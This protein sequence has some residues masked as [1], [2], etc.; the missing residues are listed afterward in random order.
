MTLATIASC[1]A[2][3]LPA[4]GVN[5][6]APVSAAASAVLASIDRVL[7]L[8][9]SFSNRWVR[10]RVNTVRSA[11]EAAADPYNVGAPPVSAA[12]PTAPWLASSWNGCT[13][14][15]LRNTALPLT[16]RHVKML[17]PFCE[18]SRSPMRPPQP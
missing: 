9:V 16:F 8:T 4:G 2:S 6:G 10:L 3:E 17:L 13:C 5:A 15:P 18:A 11:V 7:T 12:N 1:V 14:C